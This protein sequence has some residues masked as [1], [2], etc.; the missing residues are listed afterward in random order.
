MSAKAAEKTCPLG[1]PDGSILNMSHPCTARKR[2]H[3]CGVGNDRA[4]AVK[5]DREP[6]TRYIAGSK[7]RTINASAGKLAR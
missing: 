5:R 4:I 1:E 2:R 3:K 6:T 7:R